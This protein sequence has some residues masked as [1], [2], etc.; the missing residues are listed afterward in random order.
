MAAS[1]PIL[2]ALRKL[3]DNLFERL[4]AEMDR[5]F[6]EMR[7]EV[8]GRF[9]AIEVRLERLEIEYQM[10]LAALR[11]IE[12]SLTEDRADRARLKGEVAAL[13]QK[14]GDLDARARAIEATLA[15]E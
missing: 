6:T 13:R 11:R 3:E 8:N 2:G 4:T 12:E 5:R 15:E 14:I 1:D 7:V 10:I 9:D